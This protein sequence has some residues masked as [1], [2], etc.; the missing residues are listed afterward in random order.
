MAVRPDGS[1]RTATELAV[2]AAAPLAVLAG[3]RLNNPDSRR[4]W[5]LLAAALTVFLAADAASH[6]ADWADGV[7][8]AG[9]P[10]LLAALAAVHQARR[11]GPS[12]PGL[13]DS[14]VVATTAALGYWV[15]VVDLEGADRRWT[16]VQLGFL[17]GD[18]LLLALVTRLV[19]DDVQSP[20]FALVAAGSGVLVGTDVA[21][22]VTA[23]PSQGLA[24]AWAHAAWLLAGA[25]AGAAALHPSMRTVTDATAPHEEP[26]VAMVRLVLLGSVLLLPPL[27]IGL[28]AVRGDSEDF[29]VL[30]AGMVLLML[31]VLTR[32]GLLMKS[33]AL[34]AE[35][36]RTLRSAAAAFVAGGDRRGVHAAAL[37]A[38]DLLLGST[39]VV[40]R[41]VDLAAVSNEPG[42]EVV[43]TA[44]GRRAQTAGKPVAHPLLRAVEAAEPGWPR[45]EALDRDLTA[46]LDLRGRRGH[47]VVRRVAVHDELLALVLV[48]TATPPDNGT[49]ETLDTLAAQ[50]GLALESQTLSA[51]LHL[52]QGEARFRALVQNSSDAILLV[53]RS[54]VVTYQSTSA[55]RILGYPTDALLG[56]GLE[57]L[58]DPPDLLRLQSQLTEVL[59]RPGLSRRLELRLR[60]Q[61]GAFVDVEAVLNNLQDDPS[62][63]A[64]L[65][66]IRDIS[67][68]KRFE[69]TL[70]HQAFHDELTGLAN[71]ALFTDRVAH[72]LRRRGRDG[73]AM[74][75][76]LLDLDDFKTINDS[77]GHAAGDALLRAVSGRLEGLLRPGDTTARLGGDEFA[78]LLADLPAEEAAVVAV[79][80][81]LATLAQPMVIDGREVFAHA[82]IGV[83]FAG[84]ETEDPEELVRNADA[85]MYVVKTDGKG[86]Y[87]I[88]EPHMHAAA[89][90]RLDL[91]AGLQRALDN[92]EFVLHYQP[93]VSME[94]GRLVGLEAL[95][96]WEHP[97]RGL[98]APDSF[99]PLAEETGL[100]VPLGLWVLQDA[101][102]QMAEWSVLHPLVTV[103][104]NV[105]QRQLRRPDFEQDV[106]RVL[107]ESGVEPGRV[108]L[109]ITESAVMT[110]VESTIQRLQELKALGVRIAVDDF[111]TGYSSFSWLRQLPVDVLKIDKE[112]VG[113]LGRREQSGFLVATIIDLAHNLGL[114]T[115]A[116]GI[117]RTA[118][119]DR[120]RDMH[121]DLGQGF[122]LGR[123]MT[124]RAVVDLLVVEGA[125]HSQTA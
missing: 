49:L 118:Q 103:S 120:L 123:P 122:H 28:Q 3:V 7:R 69:L 62:V 67:E 34:T 75:V 111:G 71:R 21:V 85:A 101:C 2:A 124:A 116:E 10:L 17:V 87:A 42:D 55:E 78:M 47:L 99:I 40:S 94:T 77:L 23:D 74:A 86:R 88:F 81:I 108:N 30:V 91:R 41:I 107:R 119:L 95:V 83:A 22:L 5:L 96:R 6:V 80:R 52:R 93:I 14:A 19:V 31:L 65:V 113:E 59:A 100:V 109:E 12:W 43:V 84:A 97:Q 36:E 20:A 9:Y 24:P 35:R 51:E 98:M 39:V 54:A 106:D 16:A 89:V 61:D 37:D 102:R 112:F 56:F 82:S 4:P 15:F 57:D 58:S 70:T 110:D 11:S 46:R 33:V 8:L 63:G 13:V 1:S 26:G 25:L 18:V 90:H 38:V 60:R 48:V 68:R 79:E 115:V 50:L 64:T 73:L 125:R 27:T 66:T 72:A 104:V 44:G 29:A 53:D 32:V 121:C 76:L 92:D 114:R 117:E 45:V 105:S